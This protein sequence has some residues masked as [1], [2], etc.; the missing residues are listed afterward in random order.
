MES[1]AASKSET[2]IQTPQQLFVVVF[3]S[4]FIPLASILLIVKLITGG[5][6]V[7]PDA[8]T[9]KAVSGRLEPV[10]KAGV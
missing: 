8:L 10:S 6:N 3:L 9:E 7:S 5:I 1:Q 2:L 4:F